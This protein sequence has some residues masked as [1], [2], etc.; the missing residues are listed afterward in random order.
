MTEE[1]KLAEEYFK[2]TYPAYSGF[3]TFTRGIEDAV[4]Y[5]LKAGRPQ[6]NNYRLVRNTKITKEEEE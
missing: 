4:I 3:D 2:T 1:E 6:W 5:G